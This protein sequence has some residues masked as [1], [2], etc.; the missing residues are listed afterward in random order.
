M[1]PDIDIRGILGDIRYECPTCHWGVTLKPQGEELWTTGRLVKPVCNR[2]QL[3]LTR[4]VIGE[5]LMLKGTDQ[6]PK[7]A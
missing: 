1:I 5:Q 7:T 2:C 3:E 6:N 4:T